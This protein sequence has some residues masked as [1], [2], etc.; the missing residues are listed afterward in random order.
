MVINNFKMNKKKKSQMFNLYIVLNSNNSAY[1]LEPK[2][3]YNHKNVPWTHG[4]Q[5]ALDL[6]VI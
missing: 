5:L 6:N 3:T 1:K 2:N 4:S